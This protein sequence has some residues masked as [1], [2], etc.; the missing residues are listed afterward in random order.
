MCKI[1]FARRRKSH[2]REMLDEMLRDWMRCCIAL[3]ERQT[4]TWKIH[5]KGQINGLLGEKQPVAS[6]IAKLNL[7]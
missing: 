2:S 6:Y 1:S 3:T 4:N 7:V 5:V